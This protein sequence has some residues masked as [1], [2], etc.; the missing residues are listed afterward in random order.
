[1]YLVSVKKSFTIF[2]LIALLLSTSSLTL[3]YWVQEQW[4]EQER[5]TNIDAGELYAKA[6]SENYTDHQITLQLKDKSIL[7]EGYQW[8]EEGREFSH[9]GMFYDIVSLTKTDTGW[10]LIASSD[11]EEAEIV[12]KQHKS[13]H[14][15]KEIAGQHHS[16][17]Q[18]TNFNFSLYDQCFETSY[19]K[20]ITLLNKLNYTTY[21]D[22]L[23]QLCLGQVS[24]PPKAV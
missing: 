4:H 21:Q 17:K 23:M 14:A 5:F 24:P 12:A 9:E 2:C 10:E 3:F 1:M 15:D 22:R 6:Y 19:L 16:K 11:E 8:E 20:E 18:K 13:Q 7:P